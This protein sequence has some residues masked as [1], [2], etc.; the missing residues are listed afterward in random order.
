MLE[1]GA[2][3]VKISAAIG[4]TGY[5]VKVAVFVVVGFIVYKTGSVVAGVFT[6]GAYGTITSKARKST[7]TPLSKAFKATT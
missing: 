2:V 3:N 5:G 7:C 1:V 4:A 6:D